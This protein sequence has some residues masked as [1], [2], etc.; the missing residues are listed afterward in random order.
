MISQDDLRQAIEAVN[1]WINVRREQAGSKEES[2]LVL[3]IVDEKK[4]VGGFSVGNSTTL[5]ILYQNEEI[6]R[7]TPED[8]KDSLTVLIQAV[9]FLISSRYYMDWIIYGNK[10]K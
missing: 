3:G 10:G 6:A 4:K 9:L 7:V 1:E 5:R 8:M 2:R